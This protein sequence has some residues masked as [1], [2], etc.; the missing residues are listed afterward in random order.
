MCG[1][2]GFTGRVDE[3]AARAV[4]GRMAGTLAHR[5]PDGSGCWTTPTSAGRRL[6]LGHTRL[7]ILDLSDAAAQPFHRAAA[8]GRLTLVFN[9]EIYNYLELRAELAAAGHA[10]ATGSDTE[11]LL[12]AYAAWGA[13]CLPRLRG[14]YAFAVWDARRDELFLA[15]DPF[16]KKP[17]LYFRDGEDLVFASELAALAAHPAFRPEVDPA[18]LGHYLLF[19]YVPGDGSL[20]KGVRELPA[21]HMATWRAGRLEIRRHYAPPPAETDPARRLPWDA[22]TVA[23]FR[24]ELAE[25]V[26]LRMRSDVPLGAFLS[27]GIDSSSIVALMAEQSDRPVRTFSV[28]FKEEGFSELW[29]AQL[30]AE[31]FQT[32]HHELEITPADF[33][34]SLEPATRHRGAPLSEMADVPVYLISRLAARHVKV[35]LSGEGSDELLAGYAKHWG[36]LAVAR[37]QRAA[38]A[39]PAAPVLKG[40]SSL[41]GYRGRSLQVLLRAAAERDFLDRQA[42]WFGLMSRAEARRLCPGLPW[43]AIG[44]AWPD[45]P[46]EGADPL[47]RALL[48]DKTVWLPGTLLA[49]GDRLTMAASIE[50]RMPFMDVKLCAFAARLPPAA[51]LAGRTGKQ[52]L[53]RAMAATLP[54]EILERPKDGFRVPV[55]EWLRG[56]MRPFLHDMLLAPSAESAPYCD[57]KLLAALVAEHEA[58][59]RNREKELWSLLALEVF[60]RG[61]RPA[62]PRAD[63]PQAVESALEPVPH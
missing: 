55:H 16:G 27:G 3:A 30:V 15:R 28:G 32:E 8:G 47:Q 39:A 36:D 20:V 23:A 34:D 54:P 58:G 2:A 52:I 33:L 7:A 19:K 57:R 50:G 42:A 49:R 63:R 14:M 60:L 41:L 22:G 4:A 24:A 62:R 45:D 44:Y 56:R 13:D 40:A 38:P 6:A 43:H 53:R 10:F 11:V 12:A 29:A 35:V 1:I 21:G 17:L 26:R 51:F 5:G 61:L 46:G 18:A 9:G 25:A 48:F 37:F 31:R 59:R